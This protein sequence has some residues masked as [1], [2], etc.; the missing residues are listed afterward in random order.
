MSWDRDLYITAIHGTDKL[1]VAGI[2]GNHQWNAAYP[3][4]EFGIG[5]F[6][7][8]YLDPQDEQAFGENAK[9]FQKNIDEAKKLLS[10]AGHEDGLSFKHVQYPIQ[11]G[12]QQRSMDVIEGLFS[13]AGFTV[14]EQEQVT[15]PEIFTEYINNGGHFTH[16][17]NTLDFGGPDPAA[18]FRTHLHKTGSLFGGWDADGGPANKE[19]D[20]FLNDTIDKMMMEFDE[21]KRQDLAHDLIRYMGAKVYKMRYPGAGTQLGLAWPELQNAYVWRGYGLAGAFSYEFIDPSKA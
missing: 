17:L 4:G 6:T 13:E 20:P 16:L 5:A 2:P 9:Y 3:A 21:P 14:T 10:A 19:G 8:W 1:E 18:Y 11:P 12:P 7:S 15:I